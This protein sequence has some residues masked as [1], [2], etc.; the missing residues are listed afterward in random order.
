V[1]H[2]KRT[3]FEPPCGAVQCG[4]E[5]CGTAGRPVPTALNCLRGQAHHD[6]PIT[7][8]DVS[9]DGLYV[10]IG[11]RQG[12]VG[13]LEVGNHVHRN[14]LRSHS[15]PVCRGAWARVTADQF[16]HSALRACYGHRV[17]MN[18]LANQMF[19]YE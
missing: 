5:R 7:S 11:T 15:Q 12:A 17:S 2:T 6:A 8:V 19:E 3:L 14:I 13:L 16:R 10:A 4:L 18:I 1:H 9:S